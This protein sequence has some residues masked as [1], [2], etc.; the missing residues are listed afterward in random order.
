MKKLSQSSYWRYQQARLN[1]W[2][3][4]NTSFQ[5][6]KV[7]PESA[8]EFFEVGQTLHHNRPFSTTMSLG[9][10]YALNGDNT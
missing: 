4:C 2:H 3:Q 6:D 8:A 5:A 10:T 1:F 7:D 9:K